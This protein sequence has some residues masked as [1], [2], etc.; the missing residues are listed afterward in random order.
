LADTSRPIIAVGAVV[1]D[2]NDRVLLIRRAKPPAAGKWSVPGGKVKHGETL[3]KACAREVREET[4]IAI[5]P[6][7]LVE[8]VERITEGFHYVILDFAARPG[9]EPAP[10]PRAAD[11][12]EEA[13]WVGLD[14]LEDYDTT[15]G[16]V[17]VIERA[18]SLR[19]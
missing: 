8:V 1:L 18:R 17:A 3:Q 14:K 12:V 7:P 15:E 6:G 10:Q 5:A 19:P 13:R 11:D 4:G 2:A 16:L 9:T